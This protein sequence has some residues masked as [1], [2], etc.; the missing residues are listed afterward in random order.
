M[1]EW[2]RRVLLLFD[3]DGTLVRSRPLTHQRAMARGS[4]EVFGLPAAVDEQAIRAVE[5]WGKTD[6]QILAELLAA[7]GRAAAP[8]AEELE[9]W[10]RLTC[11]VYE[12][13]EDGTPDDHDRAAAA[14]LARLR[15]EG[16]ALALVTGNLEPIARR[17]LDRRGLGEYFPAGQGGFGSD[18]VDRADLVRIAR[19]RAGDPPAEQTVLIGDTPRD[20]AAALEAGVRCIGIAGGRYTRADLTAAGA[21]AA[22]DELH[23]LE[24]ILAR[25]NGQSEIGKE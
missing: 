10:E 3:I 22:V 13:I 18:A 8:T 20:V 25:M 5:P 7:H 6:R 2:R 24:P 9:R 23:E 21:A 19:E 12:E 17:K 16:H 15:D 4:V 11:A 14:V 1:P